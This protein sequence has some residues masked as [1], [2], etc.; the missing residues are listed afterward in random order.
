M[1]ALA[2]ADVGHVAITGA[3]VQTR[4]HLEVCQELGH[5][6]VKVFARRAASGDAVVAWAAEHTPGCA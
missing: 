4:S 3:G 1:E 2:P 6:D 5:L